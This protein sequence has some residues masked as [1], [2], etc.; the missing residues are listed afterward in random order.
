MNTKRAEAIEKRAN[1]TRQK[2]KKPDQCD[3]NMEELMLA[4]NIYYS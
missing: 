2:L 4:H 1:E 3:I